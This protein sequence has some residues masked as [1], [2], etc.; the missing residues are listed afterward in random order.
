[1]K[2]VTLWI[3]QKTKLVLREPSKSIELFAIIKM[4]SWVYKWEGG[5]VHQKGPCYANV[6][7]PIPDE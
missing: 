4:F 3:D 6:T 5:V 2:R 7:L 1:M